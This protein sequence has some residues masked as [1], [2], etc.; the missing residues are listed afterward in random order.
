M[1]DEEDRRPST[2]R[3]LHNRDYRLWAIG[4]FLSASGTFMQGVA[5]A[6]LVLD[7]T[8]S[9]T[10]LGFNMML[11]TIPVLLLGSWGGLLSDRFDRGRIYLVSQLLGGAQAVVMGVLVATGAAS[12][13]VICV[14]ALVL[15]AI[16]AIDQ[17]VRHSLVFAILPEEDVPNGIALNMSMQSASRILGPAAG[18]ILIAVVGVGPCFFVNAASFL[19]AVIAS[20]FVQIR[21]HAPRDGE[22]HA[23]RLLDGLRYVRD[24]RPVRLVLVSG[25]IVFM[26]AWE[27]EITVPLLAR[28]TFDGEGLM[29]G[30]FLAAQSVGAVFG[31]L[32]AARHGL[33]T[34]RSLKRGA[35]AYG[36]ALLL[37]SVAPTPLTEVGAM[38]LVGASGILF[39]AMLSTR[40]QILVPDDV[41]G[42]VTA[43]WIIAAVGTRPVGAPIV[44]SIGQAFGPRCAM[45]VGAA[46]VLGV[47]LP[48][49]SWISFRN[50]QRAARGV[51]PS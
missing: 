25:A 26:F 31:G 9:G 5:Q 51:L 21:P 22:A 43:L 49:W 11:Q 44:G 24:T 28:Y 10:A 29:L 17:P 6:W 19:P 23:P 18:G 42:R 48:S 27:Y 15:G 30:T 20:R 14:L 36:L 46:A 37:S 7:L 13:T 3:A 40:L 39:A 2:F 12:F 50:R 34:P 41:R 47:V 4:Q 33:P 16:T 1:R 32:V 8:G 38:A 45:G 35:T